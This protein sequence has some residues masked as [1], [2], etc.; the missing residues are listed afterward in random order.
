ML[1]QY[2]DRGKRSAFVALSSSRVLR[3]GF[4]LR[5]QSGKTRASRWTFAV[6]TYYGPGIVKGPG[7]ANSYAWKKD[8]R[9]AFRNALN[10]LAPTWNEEPISTTSPPTDKAVRPGSRERNPTGR[11]RYF[12]LCY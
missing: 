9:K 5:L 4:C 10:A 7:M 2:C 6:D 3:S 12:P 11:T 8:A 1:D